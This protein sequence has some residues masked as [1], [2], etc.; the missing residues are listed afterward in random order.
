MA[1]YRQRIT[2]TVFG[3]DLDDTILSLVEKDSTPTKLVKTMNKRKEA[4]GYKQGNSE[5][6]L[7]V[8]AEP[9][10]DPTIPDWH[11]LKKNRTRFTIARTDDLGVKVIYGQCVVTD[12]TDSTSDGDSSLKLSILAL[13]RN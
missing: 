6:S 2:M 5:Y 13:T 1:D 8:D 7:D 10:V 3:V 12:V 4:R 9:I 11:A